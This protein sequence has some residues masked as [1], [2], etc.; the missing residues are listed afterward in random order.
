VPPM[1]DAHFSPIGGRSIMRHAANSD[2]AAFVGCP[3]GGFRIQQM[4]E[5]L[6]TRN[7]PVTYV[8]FRDEGHGFVRPVSRLGFFA[9]AEAFVPNHLWGPATRSKV[10]SLDRR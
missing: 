4:V 1:M 6:K 9:V 5:A 10:I 8:T 3:R 2:R 7:A